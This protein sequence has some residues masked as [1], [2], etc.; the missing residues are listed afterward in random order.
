MGLTA[1][2]APARPADVVTAEVVA[3]Y[4]L[5]VAEQINQTIIKASFN[6]NIKE[7]QDCSAAL[8]DGQ[9]RLVAQADNNPAH[10]GSLLFMGEEVLKKY[11]ESVRDG[12]VFIHNDPYTRGSSHLSDLTL[13]TPIF[14]QGRLAFFAVNT[15]HHVDVGGRA[16]GSTAPDCRTIYEEGVRVPLVRL[17]EAGKLHEEMLELICYG[18]RDPEERAADLRAQIAANEIARRPLAALAE[19]HGIAELSRIV[20]RIL[21][22]AERRGREVIAALPEGRYRATV[23]MDSDGIND[24]EIP[25]TVTSEIRDKAIHFDF[26]GTG[27]QADGAMNCVESI[28]LAAIYFA[29]KAMLDPGIP[30]NSGFFRCLSLRAPRGTIV[31]PNPPA[32]VGVRIDAA[33]KVTDVVIKSLAKAC[34]PERAVAG[35]HAINSCWIFYGDDAIRKKPYVYL[36]TFGGG[37]GARAGKDGLDGIH[38]YLVNTRN[39]PVEVLEREYPLIVERY[40]FVPD[41]G[42]PGEFRGG[43]GIRRDIRVLC[44]GNYITTRS[45]GQKRGTWGALG[46]GDGA[47]ARVFRNPGS[48]REERLPGKRSHIPLRRG[49]VLSLRTPGG[50]GLGNPR[51][52]SPEQIA[53]DLANGKIG[54]AHARMAYHFSPPRPRRGRGWG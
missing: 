53:A 47:P 35:S 21:D 20:D 16:P 51:R 50:G 7:R 37:G 38:V 32:A 17:A 18:C 25:I 42:G 23:W 36:E 6:P 33:Q 1:A 11:G 9:G 29:F 30:P 27:P 40:G 48:K 45:E 8:L 52:R 43:L 46:G 31:N 10:L 26:T 49:D 41:S 15:G 2:T 14:A 28:V 12:D 4:L 5:S 39:L 44:G 54:P 24:V 22:Y 3:N 13:V 34:P 19:R